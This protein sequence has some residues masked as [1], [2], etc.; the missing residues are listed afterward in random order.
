MLIVLHFIDFLFALWCNSFMYYSMLVVK[1]LK[2]ILNIYI[3]TLRI[4]I[5]FVFLAAVIAK[6]E[7]YSS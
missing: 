2:N 4:R 7:A 3:D 5:L 6:P 1:P